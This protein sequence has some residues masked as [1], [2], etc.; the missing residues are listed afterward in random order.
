MR[1]FIINGE[2]TM[3][4]SKLNYTLALTAALLIPALVVPS[5][6]FASDSIPATH[7][8]ARAHGDRLQEHLNKLKAELKITEKQES[9]W[10]GYEAALK[11]QRAT[12]KEERKE[13][14]AES[15]KL[16]A[17]QRMD[18]MVQF[19]EKQLA[20][21]K[22]TDAA[23]KKLYKELTPEQQKVLNNAEHEHEKKMREMWEK[24]RKESKE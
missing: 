23:L 4:S 13:M 12:F 8:K 18:E 22:R 14:R 7:Q 17:V 9:A 10:H 6:S 19:H 15:G 20:N 2:I 5:A 1:R 16:T 3:K 24:V 11:H 21:L